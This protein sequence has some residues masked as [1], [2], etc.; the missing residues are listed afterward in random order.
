MS[1]KAMKLGLLLSRLKDA[2]HEEMLRYY[3]DNVTGICIET[4]RCMEI[5]LRYYGF[6]P[7]PCSVFLNIHNPVTTKII[8]GGENKRMVEES[9]NHGGWSVG[10]RPSGQTLIDPT[11]G[12]YA[13]LVLRLQD[14]LID[15][16]IKRFERPLHSIVMPKLLVTRVTGEFAAGGEPVRNVVN[17]CLVLYEYCGDQR[18]RNTPAWTKEGGK[19]TRGTHDAVERAVVNAIIERVGLVQESDELYGEGRFH[20]LIQPGPASRNSAHRCPTFE[21]DVASRCT[22]TGF[23][24]SWSGLSTNSP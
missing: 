17:D 23:R 15:A 12:Y 10:V 21:G 7:R 3:G 8:F 5:E 9:W 11:I 19:N 18:F 14:M 1:R 2:A 13:H 6:D 4:A 24:A 16:S 20:Q 22:L